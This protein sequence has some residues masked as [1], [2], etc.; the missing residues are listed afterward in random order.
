MTHD[1]TDDR[2]PRFD[3]HIHLVGNGRKGS[4]SWLKMNGW[5]RMMGGMMARM[6][7]MPIHFLHEDF[8][9]I[10]VAR[11]VEMLRTSSLDH[12]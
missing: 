8:D 4:G 11:I 6:V 5:H 7:A 3:C 2:L 10:Y 9:E 12:A 1:T